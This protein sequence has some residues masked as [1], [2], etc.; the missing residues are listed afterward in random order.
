[1]V[2]CQH[3]FLLG[4]KMGTLQFKVRLDEALH[5]SIKSAAE[6]N[7]RSVNSEIVNRLQKSFEI[8]HGVMEV[9]ATSAS[10]ADSVQPTYDELKEALIAIAKTNALEKLDK[11]INALDKTLEDMSIKLSR[12]SKG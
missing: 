10:G 7:N 1:M 4:L 5:A 3:N 6:Q 11:K 2:P 8:D 9:R 12:I